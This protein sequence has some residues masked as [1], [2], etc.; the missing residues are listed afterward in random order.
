MINDEFKSFAL[1]KIMLDPEFVRYDSGSQYGDHIDS[2]IFNI[3]APNAL[4]TDLAATIFLSDPADY[5]GGELIVYEEQRECVIKC[6]SG[7]AVIYPANSIH[8]VNPVQ[9][10]CR[11]VAVT[12]IQSYV[13]DS[14]HR[15]V[16]HD[17][18]KAANDISQCDVHAHTLLLLGHLYNNMLRMWSDL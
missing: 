1:P 4:R 13:K 11:L 17:L 2:A 5:T 9:C 8:R 12:W 7:D 18:N 6:D 15:N 3:H 14:N 16:L 10:G